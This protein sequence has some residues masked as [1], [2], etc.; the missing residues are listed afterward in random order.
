MRR[1][2]WLTLLML[3]LADPAR[4][5]DQEK[6]RRLAIETVRD[7]IKPKELVLPGEKLLRA[8]PREDLEQDIIVLQNIDKLRLGQPVKL[9]KVYEILPTGYIVAD[10]ILKAA[11]IQLDREDRWFVAIDPQN[12]QVFHL[13]GFEDSTSGFNDLVRRLQI[14]VANTS[15]AVDVA[16][17]FLK[18]T[19]GEHVL[20][21]IVPDESWLEIL[22]LSDFRVRFPRG[23]SQKELKKWRANMPSSV[24]KQLSGM[25]GNEKPEGFDIQYPYYE[26]GTLS[27]KRLFVSRDGLCKEGLDIPIH[28]TKNRAPEGSLGR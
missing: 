15:S 6:Y 24:R 14:D 21:G 17:I 27:W 20:K 8:L 26:R 18:L 5:C 25:T 4:S 7:S 28:Q 13:L 22:T 16:E 19:Q 11:I 23:D 3:C 2:A 1:I 12:G 9:L 10:G